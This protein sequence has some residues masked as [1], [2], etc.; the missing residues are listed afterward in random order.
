M[1]AC[2]HV[3]MYV[4][5][6]ICIYTHV[7][8]EFYNSTTLNGNEWNIW[9]LFVMGFPNP[10]IDHLQRS[11]RAWA[12]FYYPVHRGRRK[13]NKLVSKSLESEKL[14]LI[15]IYKALIF[16]IQGTENNSNSLL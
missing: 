14:H 6:Y 4:Y 8:F 15:L 1:Y 3:C 16:D 12:V 9:N 2:M 7:L 5:I 11:W 13:K 10:V